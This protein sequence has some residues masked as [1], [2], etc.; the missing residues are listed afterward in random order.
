MID[1]FRH[2]RAF[3]AAARTGNF[4]RAAQELHISQSAFTV[5]IRKLEQAIGAKLFDRSKRRVSLTEVGRELLGPMERLAIDAEAIVGRTQQLTELR[6]GVVRIAVLPSVAAQML[7]AM[8]SKFTELYPGVV[9][10]AKDVV[11]EK[12]VEMVKKEEVDFGIGT[13]VRRDREMTSV[14]LMVDRLCAFVPLGHPLAKRTSTTLKEL[15]ALPLILTGKDSSVRELVERA[16]KVQRL[17]PTLAYEVNYMATAIGMVKAGLGI[18]VL[19][20]CAGGTHEGL[21]IVAIRKPVLSRKIE[22]IQRKDCSLSP[23]AARMA[24]MIRSEII[25]KTRGKVE[26]PGAR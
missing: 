5:Q 16:L 2:L 23:A 12:I 4:T 24:E 8:I 14:R 6:R 18:A 21:Q 9:V 3:L 25:G 7:P 10:Q 11:A 22:M 19:P 13:Q 1:D 15:A 17:S 20:E 26:P